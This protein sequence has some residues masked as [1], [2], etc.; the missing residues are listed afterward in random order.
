MKSEAADRDESLRSVTDQLQEATAI[1]CQME[2]ALHELKSQNEMVNFEARKWKE[3]YDIE[4]KRATDYSIRNEN[5]ESFIKQKTGEVEEMRRH[6]DRTEKILQE[7]KNANTCLNKDQNG[8][9]DALSSVGR[10]IE[11]VKP[12]RGA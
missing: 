8:L 11:N 1:I 4:A 6:L 5:V 3:Q 10:H 9:K 2:K 7:Q 12:C